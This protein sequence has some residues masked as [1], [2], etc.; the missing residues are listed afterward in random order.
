MKKALVLFA[1]LVGCAEAHQVPGD[2]FDGVDGGVGPSACP[3][4]EVCD[5]FECHF[6]C[7]I[8]GPD[9]CP[10]ADGACVD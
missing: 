10:A 4:V 7:V 2:V 3:A 5:E 8:V 9:H 1:L 6:E